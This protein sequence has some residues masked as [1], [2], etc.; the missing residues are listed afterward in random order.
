MIGFRVRDP[1]TGAI[2]FSSEN[3]GLLFLDQFTVA[4]GA[5]E[6]RTYSRVAGAEVRVVT[7]GANS[8]GANAT[9]TITPSGDTV[10]VAISVIRAGWFI[11][12]ME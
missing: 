10:T 9:I 2:K 6:S 3:L 4:A 11:L 12:T 5:T 1:V 8:V 7:L